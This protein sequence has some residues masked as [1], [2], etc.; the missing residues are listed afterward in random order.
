MDVF[1]VLHKCAI[2]DHNYQT[3]KGGINMDEK[4]ETLL[5]SLEDEHIKVFLKK[6]F[7]YPSTKGVSFVYELN[8]HMYKFTLSLTQH[9]QNI[10]ITYTANALK[11]NKKE[12]LEFSFI[13]QKLIEKIQNASFLKIKLALR[14]LHLHTSNIEEMKYYIRDIEYFEKR[15][16]PQYVEQNK[17]KIN[18]IFH[19]SLSS[20]KQK[21]TENDVFWIIKEEDDSI[22]AD[23]LL[24]AG[25]MQK[26]TNVNGEDYL[27]LH[28]SFQCN[29]TLFFEHFSEKMKTLGYNIY[30]ETFL[31]SEEQDEDYYDYDFSSIFDRF[32]DFEEEDYEEYFHIKKKK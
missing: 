5:H 15:K 26:V 11:E 24:A 32:Y 13:F 4:W 3:L 1:F 23:F 19:S 2:I 20:S 17:E 7:S 16:N 27:K 31:F 6:S 25:Y 28:S 18:D 22:L 29:A 30:Y 21:E 14:Q 12:R 9:D 8:E 10:T